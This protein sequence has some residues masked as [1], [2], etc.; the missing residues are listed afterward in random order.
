MK[1]SELEENKALI[2]RQRHY[3]TH[4]F[5]KNAENIVTRRVILNGE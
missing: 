1:A 3:S 5:L 2:Y 4:E